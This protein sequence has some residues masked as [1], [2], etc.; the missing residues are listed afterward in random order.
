[1]GRIVIFVCSL[2]LCAL[3]LLI[4]DEV[5]NAFLSN[6]KKI[7]IRGILFFLML[8]AVIDA[9]LCLPF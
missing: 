8:I 1:M 2:M 3:F 5:K 4:A 7:I 6:N 9:C